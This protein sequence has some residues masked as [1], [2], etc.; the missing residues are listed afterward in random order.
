MPGFNITVEIKSP[1]SLCA[2]AHK[3]YGYL[4]LPDQDLEIKSLFTPV[5]LFEFAEA[6][7]HYPIMFSNND[8]M[9]PVAVTGLARN[10]DRRQSGGAYKTVT[11]RLYPFTLEKLPNQ[12][13][14]IVIFDAHSKQVVSLADDSNAL[15]FFT[16]SGEPSQELRNLA[17]YLGQL[18][19][20]RR[21]AEDFSRALKE[22]GLLV[23]QEL[24]L[25]SNEED[26]QARHLF[27]VINQKA[28]RNLPEKTVHLWFQNGWLDAAHMVLLSQQHW[29]Q[30]L[31]PFMGK[32]S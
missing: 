5:A 4:P 18:Y 10:T 14:G 13:A 3:N 26:T 2:E 30:P 16:E 22:A 21:S 19:D 1:V 17:G 6:A 12:N 20:G 25:Q 7:Q 28:Y 11:T 15:P 31:K 27:Y 32:V 8:A 23:P 9:T 24:I 29:S